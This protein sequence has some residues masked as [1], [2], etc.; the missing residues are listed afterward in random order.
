MVKSNSSPLFFGNIK[1][2]HYLCSVKQKDMEE[3]KFNIGDRVVRINKHYYDNSFHNGLSNKADN[4]FITSSTVSDV[5]E[6]PYGWRGNVF[7]HW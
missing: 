2:I 1:K 6:Y 3:K 7:Y 4:H 5:Y